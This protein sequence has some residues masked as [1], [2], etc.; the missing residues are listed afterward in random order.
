MRILFIKI[1]IRDV[2]SV[3]PKSD[4]LLIRLKIYIKK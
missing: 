4:A 2:Y 1:F 3:A